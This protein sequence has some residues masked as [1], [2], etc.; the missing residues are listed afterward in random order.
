MGDAFLFYLNY[1][2]LRQKKS[3]EHPDERVRPR[4]KVSLLRLPKSLWRPKQRNSFRLPS[5]IIRDLNQII[6]KK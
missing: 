2:N 5:L 4:R 3:G 6:I 1:H